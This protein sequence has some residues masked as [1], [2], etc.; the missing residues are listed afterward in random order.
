F[1]AM[2]MAHPRFEALH[3]PE[4]NILCFRHL[5]ANPGASA[6]AMGQGDGAPGDAEALDELNR[7][8]RE[9]YNASGEGWIT[10]TVLDGRRVLRVTIINPRTTETHLQRLLDGIDRVAL[11]IANA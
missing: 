6:A 3:L 7:L 9:R 5:G 11:D 1:H 4:T 8:T 10:S 2:V